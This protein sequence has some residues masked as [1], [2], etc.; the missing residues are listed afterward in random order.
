ML[1][2]QQRVIDEKTELDHRLAKLNLFFDHTTFDSLPNV[3][4]LRMRKQ[5]AIMDEY[6]NILKERIEAFQ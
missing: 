5:A 4:K 2:F 6:S 1:S 3:E